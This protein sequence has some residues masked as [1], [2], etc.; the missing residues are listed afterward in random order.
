MKK[1]YLYCDKRS[2]NDATI[3]YVEIVND[4]LRGLGYEVIT[5]HRLNEIINPALI[6][7]ISNYNFVKAKLRFPF[8][9][10]V[11]WAQGISYE[12][13]KMTRAYWKR[14]PLWIFEQITIWLADM[15][16]FVSD[17]M[18]EYY[19]K[20]FSYKNNRHVI[21]PCYNLPLGELSPLERYVSPTFVYAGGVSQW[22]GIDVLLDT[23]AKIEAV[24]P[25]ASL[26]MY[27]KEEDYIYKEAQKRDIKNI[28]VKYIPLDQLQKELSQYKYGFI[29][30]EKNW[31]NYVATPTKMNS[32]LAA[33]LIPIFSNGV[34]DFEQNINLGEFTIMAKTP[35]IPNAIAEQIIAFEN[36]DHCYI[37]YGNI[38][39]DVFEQHYNNKYY[40]SLIIRKLTEL[41][42]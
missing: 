35:L 32:Y 14:Y 25:E 11:N 36:S 6:F 34:N 8:V 21:M 7:T 27:C 5:V 37:K 9:R 26:T 38:V 40:K 1:A 23:Y 12:E 33:Y 28:T 22:Q 4:C 16:L 3:Y 18:C 29:L 10:S 41:G 19:R 42:M 15:H 17:M 30:R 24:I 31:V 20:H 2:L 13:A 39:K